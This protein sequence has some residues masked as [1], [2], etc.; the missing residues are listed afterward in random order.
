MLQINEG[1]A[2]QFQFQK[3]LHKTDPVL[4]K[5]QR[6]LAD[7]AEKAAPG[8]VMI[9]LK[10]K[11]T[12][13]TK[14]PLPGG[15]GRPGPTKPTTPKRKG[16]G[17]ETLVPP[18]EAPTSKGSGFILESKGQRYIVTNA[19]VVQGGE[20]TAEVQ[21][22]DGSTATLPVIDYNKSFDLALLKADTICPACKPVELSEES[23]P[24]RVMEWVI[25]VG[26]PLG[27]DQTNTFGVISHIKRDPKGAADTLIDDFIQIDAAVNHGN[28]GG[29]LFNTDG[30]VIGVNEA[31]ISPTGSNVGIALA[32]PSKYVRRLV[33]R[34]EKTGALASSR[35][36]AALGVSGDEIQVLR[37]FPDS[38]AL[39]AGLQ[40][41]DQILSLDEEK[42]HGKLNQIIMSVANKI[43]GQVMVVR[44]KRNGAEL[45]VPVTLE[46]NR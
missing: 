21:F 2:P 23:D 4:K 24:P 15:R 27:L 11:A 20:A 22:Y 43:P 19:H 40:A 34:F 33:E 16:P 25:A 29:P 46:A 10:M 6:A 38:P 12:P 13:V 37:I 28:S 8:V 9:T 35:M 1:E 44:V 5:A 18:E 31:I 30:D 39:K 17:T 7:I 14:V 26:A 45:D 3:V 36:G 32:I 41:G 42:A